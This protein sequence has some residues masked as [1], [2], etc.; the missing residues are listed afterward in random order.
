MLARLIQ[1]GEQVINGQKEV[2]WKLGRALRTLGLKVSSVS[3]GLAVDGRDHDGTITQQ[4]WE[5]FLA[6]TDEPS[7]EES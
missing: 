3:G 6:V 2:I 1:E 4:Q 7:S 5:R